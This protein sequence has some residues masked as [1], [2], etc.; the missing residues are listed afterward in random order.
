MRNLDSKSDDYALAPNC[1][2]IDVLIVRFKHTGQVRKA[3]K[4]TCIEKS[5]ILKST[6][7][8]GFEKLRWLKYITLKVDYVLRRDEWKH[9]A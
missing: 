4:A 7:V 8:R 9:E 2:Y 6:T 5:G 1:P 3:T